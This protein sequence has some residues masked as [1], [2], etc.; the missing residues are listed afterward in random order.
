MSEL[1]DLENKT[2]GVC[3][4]GSSYSHNVLSR[5]DWM[6]T[7]HIAGSVAVL[8]SYPIQRVL[9]QGVAKKRCFAGCPE[10][11]VQVVLAAHLP[12]EMLWQKLPDCQLPPDSLPDT[13]SALLPAWQG[14]QT[15]FCMG[16]SCKYMS[17]LLPVHWSLWS[18]ELWKHSKQVIYDRW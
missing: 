9:T 4:Q 16:P 14:S 15:P 7:P 13:D 8:S 6:P 2:V 12:L 11:W 1:E 17:G 10:A 18:Y 5:V 3:F